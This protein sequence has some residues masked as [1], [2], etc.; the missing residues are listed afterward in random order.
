M[1]VVAALVI[2]GIFGLKFWQFR[3]MG[4]AM[5]AQKPPPVTVSADVAREATWRPALRTTGALVAVQGV[6]LSNEYAGIVDSI[7]FEAGDVVEKGALLVQLNT[8]VDAA[9]LHSNE[10]AAELARQTLERARSL[11]ESNANAQAEFDAAKTQYDQALASVELVRATIAKKTIRA[12]FSGRL[13][14]RQVNLGQFL[15]VGTAIVSLQSL[16]PIYVEFSLPQ[17]Q[18]ANVHPGQTVE[19]TVDAFGDTAFSGVINAVDAT[20]D[21][22]TRTIRVQ[23][24]L[25]NK[26][27]RLQPG[28]FGT[29][30][31]LL[32]EQQKII[33]VPQ[34]AITYNPYGNL[35]YVIEPARGAA[36]APGAL[37]VRQQFVKLGETRGDQVAVLGGLKA[38]EQIV[39]SGQL[40]LRDGVGVRI[41]NT[42]PPANNP[43]PTPP[44]A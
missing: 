14:L 33:T 28:M 23:A 10:A 20:L 18:V 34:S 8:S 39:T 35:I 44:N 30:A 38:G 2:G 17:Q 36:A 43:A 5:A 27:S 25:E 22:A 9:Q 26:A 11:R 6:V 40:K 41:D 4:K 7:R 3:Q 15:P 16:D 37:V 24:T 12:P 21:P 1:L 19:L 29:V 32:P 31:V 42:V 13:G